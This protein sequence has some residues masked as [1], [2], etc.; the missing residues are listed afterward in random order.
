MDFDV[1]IAM[2]PSIR[3]T[4]VEEGDP[5]CHSLVISDE[6]CGKVAGLMCS[7]ATSAAACQS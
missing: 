5:I 3:W 2:V 6:G 7:L 4:W 1:T